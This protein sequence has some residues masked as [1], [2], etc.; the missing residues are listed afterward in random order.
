MLYLEADYSHKTSI[1][2]ETWWCKPFIFQIMNSV[3]W[4]SQSLKYQMFTQPGYKDIG[5]GKIMFEGDWVI[6]SFV[7][8]FRLTLNYK[9]KRE[10]NG[11]KNMNFFCCL[12]WYFYQINYGFIK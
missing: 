4:N 3:K 9:M 2:F 7:Q 1:F 6:I 10:K 5:I 8:N 12:D 11:N